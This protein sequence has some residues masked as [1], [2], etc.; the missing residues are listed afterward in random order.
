MNVLFAGPWDLAGKATAEYFWREGHE[1]C[2]LTSEEKRGLWNTKCKGAVCRGHFTAA[3][4]LELLRRHHI[5]AVIVLTAGLREGGDFCPAE[6]PEGLA[7]LLTALREYPVKSFVYL[8]SAELGWRGPLTPRQAALASGELCCRAARD[9]DA[10]PLLILRM[11]WLYGRAA[12][13]DMG[14]TGAMLQ[15]I[16]DGRPIRCAYGP[17][18]CIDALTA[19]DAAAA[20]YRMVLHTQ[21][22]R[23]LLVTGHPLSLQD[24]CH[25]LERAADHPAQIQWEGQRHTMDAAQYSAAP[26]KEATGWM[27]YTLLQDEGWQLLRDALDIV[28]PAPAPQA[29]AK[30]RFGLGHP[31]LRSAAETLV[32]FG[33]TLLLLRFSKDVSD[34]KYVDIR[35]M[36]VALVASCYGSG[37]GLAAV[38]L[39]SLSYLYSLAMSYVDISYLLYSVDTWVPFVI[40]AVTGSVLGYLSGRRRD[41]MAALR[42]KNRLLAEKFDQLQTVQGETLEIKSRLQQRITAERHSFADLY[43]IVQELDRLDP[44][45]ILEHAVSIV[46]DLLQ[47]DHVVVYRMTDDGSSAS[48]AACSTAMQS[49]APVVPDSKKLAAL[50]ADFARQPVIVNIDLTPGRP[51]LAAA[52]R[53]KDRLYGIV[54]AYELGPERFTTYYRD[55]L[56]VVVGLIERDLVRALEA[57]QAEAACAGEVSL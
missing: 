42:R 38:A 49:R 3:Q 52:I 48:L 41:E 17:D 28:R 23:Y 27:A 50:C 35:L 9:H 12:P 7:V 34:L 8:S 44:P 13:E 15:A 54:A 30:T 31:L 5:D 19:A 36:F 32:L 53:C 26:L 43:R 4:I 56:K 29:P 46:E 20:I 16:R 45:Q 47:C 37:M 1:I 6:R 14:I 11:G 55:L 33:I 24:Y 18:D 51:D 40:Y 22:G 21:T 2:W 25:C 10:L 57:P 39:A